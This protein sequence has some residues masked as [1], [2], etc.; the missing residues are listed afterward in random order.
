M[1]TATSPASVATFQ[2]IQVPASSVNKNAFFA[3]TRRRF[4]TEKS[5]TFA[6]L[7]ST[8]TISLLKADILSRIHLRFTGSVTVTPGTG[9]VA[10]TAQWPYGIAGNINFA[11]NGASNLLNLSGP[12]AK[13]FQFIKSPGLTDRGVPQKIGANTVTQGTLSTNS[14]SWGLGQ[15]Q[16]GIAAGTYDVD[17]DWMLPIAE[18]DRDLSGAIFCQ[19]TS[20]D[21]TLS[22]AWAQLND[23]FALTGNAAVAVAGKFTV[24]VERFSIPSLN[25]VEILPDLSLFHAMI[26]NRNYAISNGQ[27]DTN[28]AGQGAGK[29]LLRVVARVMS[30][31]APGAPLAVSAANYGELGWKYGTAETPERFTDGQSIRELNEADYGVDLAAVWGFWSLDF[32]SRNAFRDAVDMG[33]TSELRLSTTIQNSVALTNPRLSYVQETVFASGA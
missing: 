22:I 9:T 1:T 15:S 2:G 31:A 23:I 6:G 24:E 33:Q 12:A 27:A 5:L 20:M 21:I 28:L 26:E 29:S 4:S 18:D 13:A 25:G 16:T 3:L 7:G 30:G 32:M 8:D 10:T 17:I 19:T 11:A 14:E